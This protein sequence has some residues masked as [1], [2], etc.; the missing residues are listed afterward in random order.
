MEIDYVC[1][2]RYIIKPSAE[3]NTKTK[4]GIIV[5]TSDD[6]RSYKTG[7]ITHVGGGRYTETGAKLLQVFNT[8]ELV[9]YEPRNQIEIMLNDEPHV[10]I[11][12]TNI[13]ASYKN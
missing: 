9:I 3:K 6:A 8:N 2:D 11:R 12:Q 13:I 10:I 1:E 7:V 4:S 5:E